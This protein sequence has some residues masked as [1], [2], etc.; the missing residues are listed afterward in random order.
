MK[1]VR[2]ILIHII[3]CAAG[4]CLLLIFPPLKTGYLQA[5]VTG[6][7][8]DAIS[9]A[10]TTLAQP[11]GNYVIFINTGIH[12]QE[13]LDTW[14]TFFTD[15]ENFTFSMENIACAVARGDS[16][17]QDMAASFQSQLPENQMQLTIENATVLLSRMQYGKYDMVLMSQEFIDSYGNVD[18]GKNCLMLHVT[19]NADDS[20]D[21][22]DDSA[23][24]AD[25]STDAADDSAGAAEDS[26]ADSGS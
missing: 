6:Q 26:S 21:A 14:T 23:D 1:R 10:T 17:A 19:G 5:A 2:D 16:G 20:A 25:D 3:F 12:D 7:S 22:A 8:L 18:G 11:T 24:A 4:I 15:Y 13:S 9:S